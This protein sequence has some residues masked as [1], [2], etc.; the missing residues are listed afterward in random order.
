MI[1]IFL[2]I[3]L[4]SVSCT[5][6][7]A[8][9]NN[10]DDVKD[11]I[12][13][14]EHFSPNPKK[15]VIHLKEGD[16][17]LDPSHMHGVSFSGDGPF[18]T[19]LWI[20]KE[21]NGLT[22]TSN[23]LQR[24]HQDAIYDGK[25]AL[26]AKLS[27]LSIHGIG[28]GTGIVITGVIPG[29][30]TDEVRLENVAFTNL[31]V[32]LEIKGPGV[33]ECWFDNLS[34]I[35]CGDSVLIHDEDVDGAPSDGTNELFFTNCKSLYPKRNAVRIWNESPDE[36]IRCIFWNGGMI[37]SRTIPSTMQPEW[38]PEPHLLIGTEGEKIR[39]VEFRTRW[40]GPGGKSA[41]VLGRQVQETVFTG[42]W[43]R[44]KTKEFVSYGK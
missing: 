32:G 43:E 11:A 23:S 2:L 9:F 36:T 10:I 25:C 18:I 27:N 17:V 15:K 20:D 22:V 34:F 26:G 39:I 28:L 14:Y 29:A 30:T 42:P 1:R 5:S 7:V 16:Y 3:I 37:H 35:N 38:M 19:R 4:T 13:E 24:R 8:Q 40:V 12:S 31:D 21:I 33:R 44:L 41:I 6:A